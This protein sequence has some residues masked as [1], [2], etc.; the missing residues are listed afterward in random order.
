MEQIILISSI[1]AA[2][3][4]LSEA[5]IALWLELYKKMPIKPFSCGYCLSFWI[6]LGHY[7]IF[8]PQPMRV[9]LACLCAVINSFMFKYL[10]K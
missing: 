2:G 10:N 3:F 7:S 8:D 9:A 4:V 5:I 6:G 1:S